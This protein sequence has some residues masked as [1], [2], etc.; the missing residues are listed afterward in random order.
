MSGAE[1]RELLAGRRVA[2]SALF[3]LG[4]DRRRYRWR[5]DHEQRAG[6]DM[7]GQLFLGPDDNGGWWA[8]GPF[9]SETKAGHLA[10]WLRHH[11]LEVTAASDGLHIVEHILLRPRAA[12]PADLGEYALKVTLVFPAW[13]VR[14]ARTDF[15]SFVEETA[16]INCPAHLALRC[17]WLNMEEMV[18]F[19]RAYRRWT[20]RLRRHCDTALPKALDALDAA[21]RDLLQMIERLSRS[22]GIEGR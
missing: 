16:R 21:A 6:G 12:S 7:G 11:M 15:Q 14:T 5:T 17:L 18:V 3:R 10:D 19:E 9:A 2:A 4:V 8:L 20:R 1:A 22:P 13:T